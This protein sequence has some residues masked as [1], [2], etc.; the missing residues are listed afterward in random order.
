MRHHLPPCL[1]RLLA[2]GSCCSPPAGRSGPARRP[3]RR[4]RSR[5]SERRGVHRRCRPQLGLRRRRAPR[6]DRL[7]RHRQPA[8]RT[9]R[10]R[11]RGGRPGRPDAAAGLSGRPRPSGRAAASPWTTA[12]STTPTTV[13]AVLDR[14][15]RL[16]RARIPTAPWVRGAGWQLPL[17]PDANPLERPARPAGARPA[18]HA[19]GR[20]RPLR[21]GQL[22]R[23]G[24]RRH[25]PGHARPA[26]R[27]DRAGR[28]AGEPS[29]TLRESAIDLVSAVLPAD[30]RRRDCGGAR[31]RGQPG[32]ALRHHDDV[33]GPDRREPPRARSPRPTA[34]AR[35][36]C[37]WWPRLPVPGAGGD[38]LLAPPPDWR[39]RYATAARPSHGGQA[40]PGRRHRVP[41][42]RAA[43]AL[44]RPRGDAGT[45]VRDQATLDRLVAALDRDGSRS[46]CT[47]SAT[48][49]SAWR[50]MRSARAARRQRPARRPA[51]A[52]PTSS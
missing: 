24:A 37:A 38:S 1:A 2:A 22:A 8:R 17:F 40:L 43:R 23:A 31:A 15:S 47:P 11:H 18:G 33:R 35:S 51:R 49:P 5:V 6:A 10:T 27:P 25:H 36:P 34:R 3:P 52:S 44:P 16:G 39:T 29:G 45:P 28:R 30:H 9:G 19:V 26:E 13:D 20:G 12:T 48:A 7:R 4:R 14:H 41:H 46:T 42:R 32:R 50:S 21:L